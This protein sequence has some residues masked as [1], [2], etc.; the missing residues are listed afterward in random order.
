[1][2]EQPVR[3]VPDEEHAQIAASTFRMLSDP[4]RV[5]ILWA[6]FQ[7]ESS[8]NALADIVGATP[9]AVSQHL[10]KLRLS[11]LVESRKEGTFAYY[12]A[13]DQHVRRLLTETL[14]HAEHVTGAA[15][16]RDPHS[17]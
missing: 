17:Y 3:A 2:H 7:E 14:S 4:T 16:E 9:A 10:A 13:A 11:G 1:M 6:L 5:K 15:E 12:R 8:V